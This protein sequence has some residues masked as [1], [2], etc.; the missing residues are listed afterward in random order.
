[1]FI[2]AV[3]KSDRQIAR[4]AL[5]YKVFR[6]GNW[7][8]SVGT[9]SDM[10]HVAESNGGFNLVESPLVGV[11]QGSK[12]PGALVEFEPERMELRIT[13][14][15]GSG[16]PLYYHQ[17]AAGEFF[18]STHFAQLRDVGV[19]L[20]ADET[21][22]PEFLIYRYV[23]PPATLYKSVSHI[24]LGATLRVRLT[25]DD[26]EVGN[27]EYWFPPEASPNA[28]PGELAEEMTRLLA[29]RLQRLAPLRSQIAV[30]LSGG[31]DST[32]LFRTAQRLFEISDSYSTGYPFE[33]AVENVERQ[34]AES[35]AEALGGRHH[36]Y[37]STT[38]DYLHGVLSAIAAAEQPVHH[39]QSV[40][41]CLLFERGIPADKTVI[42]SGEGA[43][44][45]C[46]LEL[47]Y[48]LWRREHNT[49]LRT[50]AARLPVAPAIRWLTTKIGRGSGFFEPILE[51]LPG[52]R[53][54]NPEHELW[55]LF[56]Y[57]N[58]RWVMEQFGCH[59]E[60]LIRSRL[61]L[62]KR[63]QNRS[64]Y[65]VI[66][67]LALRS[68]GTMTQTIWSKI[69]EACG[70][71]VDYPFLDPDLLQ[72]AYRT[73]WAV[74][75]QEPKWLIRG[76]LRRL[77]VPEFIIRRPK[78]GFGLNRRDWALKGGI[79]DPLVPLA[80]KV[81]PEEQ[82]R[83]LQTNH[84]LDAATFWTL[85]NYAIWKR[86]YVD[87]ESPDCLHEELERQMKSAALAPGTIFHQL[88]LTEAAACD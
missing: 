83:T 88:T 42:I 75:L 86:L 27:L 70:R 7:N 1:M 20:Q 81:F 19:R 24:P 12:L 66:S 14:P 9:R 61:E 43:D 23:V 59:K 39:L 48:R 22:I 25:P 29:A 34:Y 85:L 18:C 5:D 69:G 79:L 51:P 67:L 84:R 8:I 2:V 80:A 41:F 33:K 77:N 10:V 38:S 35:A 13:K 37:R 15:L 53:Y 16:R 44:V 4:S 40:M 26:C 31:L 65:D 11:S 73:S 36:Y 64:I 28:S 17:N 49:A 74:K 46:G 21:V 56:R 55:S 52:T 72:F 62:V 71:F 50:L 54:E 68:E 82:I 45:I 47:Q 3:T 60:D 57:G 30:L 76:A 58:T 63:I 32:A 6:H 87:G 78:S